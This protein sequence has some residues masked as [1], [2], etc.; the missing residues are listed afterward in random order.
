[1]TTYRAPGHR[2]GFTL[3]ELLIVIAII[4]LL[5][6]LL[7]PAVQKIRGK[8][9]I[10]QCRSDISNLEAGIEAYKSTYNVDYLPSAFIISADY[11]AAPSTGTTPPITTAQKTDSARYIRTVWGRV[12]LGN[13][14]FTGND[15]PADGNQCLV[16]FLSG[17]GRTGFS[18][19]PR[20]FAQPSPGTMGKS[21]FEFQTTRIDAQGHFTDPWGTPYI[22]FSSKEGN[23]YNF[24]G[25]YYQTTANPAFDGAG[26]YNNVSVYRESAAKF[27]RA[28]SYQIISAGPDTTFGPGGIYVPGN[29][30]YSS[31]GVGADDMSNFA[32]GPLVTGN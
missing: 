6:G 32:S 25:L 8:G 21:F 14:G 22:Y 27:I 30:A 4:G 24:F 19:A 18:S 17:P 20:P 26:G 15:I 2:R 29:L 23:D 3:I 11:T 31:S 9:P 12:A 16:F 7:L 10:V 13:T 5:I 28:S 1:M